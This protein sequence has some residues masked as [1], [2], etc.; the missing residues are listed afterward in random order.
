[1]YFLPRF[2]LDKHSGRQLT[3]QHHRGVADLNA[4]FY[5]QPKQQEGG[6][7][8]GVGSSSNSKPATRKHILLVSTFQMTVLML[9]NKRESWLFEVTVVCACIC[10]RL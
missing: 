7:E 1:M 5:T 9:F 4:T 2:Y 3:L 8:G 6:E 10:I